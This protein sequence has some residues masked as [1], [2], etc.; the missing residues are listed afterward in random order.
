MRFFIF[1]FKCKKG[2][3][4]L[5]RKKQ[6]RTC[7]LGADCELFAGQAAANFI[8]RVHADAVDAGWVKLHDVGL[9]VGW[10]D[11]S[12]CVHVI[13]GVWET[14]AEIRIDLNL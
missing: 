14:Q 7:F 13:P 3:T 5:R 9:I 12:G 6:T 11:V 4:P 1:I 10:R 2:Q 8:V